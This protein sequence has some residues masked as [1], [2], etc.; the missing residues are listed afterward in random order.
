MSTLRV[1]RAGRRF[2]RLINVGLGAI[3]LILLISYFLYRNLLVMRY[4]Y[5]VGV[6]M[7]IIFLLL[8][9]LLTIL[10]GKLA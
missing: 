6:P 9:L 2:R 5:F 8:A 3:Y 4:P 1:Y 10:M 7:A